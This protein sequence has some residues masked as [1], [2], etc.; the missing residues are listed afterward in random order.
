ML[1]R[2]RDGKWHA[3]LSSYPVLQALNILEETGK[4]PRVF[5]QDASRNYGVIE[6]KYLDNLKK[7]FEISVEISGD[8]NLKR[9]Q[10]CNDEDEEKLKQAAINSL[11][12]NS[13]FYKDEL[14][15]QLV[16]MNDRTNRKLL[17]KQLQS[18]RDRFFSGGDRELQKWGDTTEYKIERSSG[19]LFD[20]VD[21]IAVNVCPAIAASGSGVFQNLNS[22]G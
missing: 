4:W 21:V 1:V 8:Q 22:S 15:Y 5:L 10:P 6:P 3:T 7:A 11:D 13:P 12:K 20:T 16:S 14:Q 9:V 18:F 17:I 2:T 19:P